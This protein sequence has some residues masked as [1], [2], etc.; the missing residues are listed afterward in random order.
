MLLQEHSPESLPSRA[1]QLL[2]DGESNTSHYLLWEP[3]CNYYR[4]ESEGK[5]L[6]FMKNTSQTP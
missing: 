4:H 1:Y 6:Q 2:C 3:T 5:H